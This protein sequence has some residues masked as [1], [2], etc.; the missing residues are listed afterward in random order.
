VS[1]VANTFGAPSTGVWYFLVG[2]V[3]LDNDIIG[4]SVNDGTVDTAAYTA[5][6]VFDGTAPFEIGRLGSS[7]NIFDGDI[8]AVG[9]W[10]RRLSTG[11]ITALYNGGTGLELDSSSLV[12]PSFQERVNR[13]AMF[14]PG[15]AR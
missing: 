10:S 8:D 14:S 9:L 6:S 12:R 3:D 11:E 4:I 7:D 1:A 15:L 5:S 13:P 2:F